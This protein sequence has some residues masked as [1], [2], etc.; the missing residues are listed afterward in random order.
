MTLR[1]K[2]LREIGLPLV[3]VLVVICLSLFVIGCSGGGS[4]SSSEPEATEVTPASADDA[5][6]SVS[7]VVVGT[8]AS[9]APL[10]GSVRLVDANGLLTSSADIQ[11]DGT[12]S[13]EVDGMTSPFMVEASST[14]DGDVYYSFS[15]GA[16]VANI[17]PLTS[18][19]VFI[20]SGQEP[21][22]LFSSWINQSDT[23]DETSLDN[24]S[25]IIYE[26]LKDLMLANNVDSVD[27][28]V[29]TSELEAN[30]TGM[31]GVLDAVDVAWD[32]VT[33]IVT[34]TAT[35]DSSTIPFNADILVD[36]GT[37]GDAGATTDTAATVVTVGVFRQ[38]ADMSYTD[39]GI[40]LTFTVGVHCETWDRT[41]QGDDFNASPHLHY[42]A[43]DLSFYSDDSFGWTEFGPGHTLQEAQDTCEA[44][45]GGVEKVV[46]STSFYKDKPN[47]YLKITNVTGG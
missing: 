20:A 14:A 23:I 25:L 29:Y 11:V 24:A 10:S 15:N 34:I 44:G 13:L 47:V 46:N 12:Y 32:A 30:G 40:T 26:N 42:N 39:T 41:T 45:V 8:A 1:V 3:S 2:T 9:G 17:T 4:S 38:E 37:T 27:A 5:T 7:P 35:G 18:L 33:G 28:N 43:A 19:G 36:T 31:D 21:S 6:A 22:D 16:G